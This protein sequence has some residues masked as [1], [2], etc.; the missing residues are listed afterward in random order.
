MRTRRDKPAALAGPSRPN[1]IKAFLPQSHLCY[2]RRGSTA[3]FTAANTGKKPKPPLERCETSLVS[4]LATRRLSC[5]AIGISRKLIPVNSLVEK[6]CLHG[7]GWR[8]FRELG[9]LGPLCF[10]MACRQ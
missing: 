7:L 1:H 4:R 5:P 8:P 10:Y 3:A 2:P 9:A 6:P